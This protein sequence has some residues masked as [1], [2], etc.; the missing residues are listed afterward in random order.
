M[1]AI[2]GWSLAFYTYSKEEYEP[3]IFPSGAFFGTPEEGLEIG[4]IYLP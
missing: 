1:G 2:S 4:G 3:C